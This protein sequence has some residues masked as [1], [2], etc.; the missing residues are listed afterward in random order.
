MLLWENELR[1]QN[2]IT[3]QLNWV[4]CK[5]SPSSLAIFRIMTLDWMDS[6]LGC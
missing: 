1:G 6:G 2:E 4:L 5:P 3:A